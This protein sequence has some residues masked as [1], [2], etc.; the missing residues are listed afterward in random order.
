MDQVFSGA[1]GEVSR[2]RW[3]L[4][5]LR[6]QNARAKEQISTAN[7]RLRAAE[8]DMEAVQLQRYQL[9]E[10]KKLG[11]KAA[12]RSAAIAA[13]ASPER[14]LAGR[15]IGN[16][17]AAIEAERDALKSETA[18]LSTQV[19]QQ[20]ARL[21]AFEEELEEARSRE[22]GLRAE[23]SMARGESNAQ[24]D[25]QLLARNE[26]L[27]QQLSDVHSCA[28]AL[29]RQ[30]QEANERE[31]ST[32]GALEA[33]LRRLRAECEAATA[34]PSG[35]GA[36]DAAARNLR[37]A[38]QSMQPQTP[39]QQSQ[40]QQPEKV[41]IMTSS[42]MR[43]LETEKAQFPEQAVRPSA[44]AAA[45]VA[46][47]GATLHSPRPVHH[48]A[49]PVRQCSAGAAPMMRQQVPV[50]CSS[51]PVFRQVSSDL[52]P[53]PPTQSQD[54]SATGG[55]GPPPPAG[56]VFRRYSGSG[57]V[58]SPRPAGANV[59]GPSTPGQSGG[60]GAAV[61]SGNSATGISA[62]ALSVSGRLGTTASLR[63]GSDGQPP[64]QASA[65]SQQASQGGSSLA[66]ANGGATSGPLL[67]ASPAPAPAGSQGRVTPQRLV[68]PHAGADSRW[69]YQ[70]PSGALNGVATAPSNTMLL[71]ATN[72]GIQI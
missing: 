6:A 56:Q 7:A 16:I 50:S 65:Q 28:D 2:A 21:A 34:D 27:Q 3:E 60:G 20:R 30:L 51:V 1:D 64:P 55:G 70:L 12:L 52:R 39:Q 19:Q 47:P 17:A 54:G 13:D 49:V 68:P 41:I 61:S 23:L 8:H 26:D 10:A 69:G 14:S 44:A 35:S 15:E 45:L 38:R 22:M 71:Q 42:S 36:V 62:P 46:A 24:Q 72:R 25:E 18:S 57:G 43:T 53:L 29:R 37:Q 9:G 5:E 67:S 63:T 31:A 40:Q 48:A 11:A 66:S 32:R 4:S 33:E 59:G 58:T